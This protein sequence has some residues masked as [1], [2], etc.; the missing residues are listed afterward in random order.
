MHKEPKIYV[1]LSNENDETSAANR[2]FYD[3][4]S[5]FRY[6]KLCEDIYGHSMKIVSM[7]LM[8]I[9]QTIEEIERLK[10]YEELVHFIHKDY[11]ELSHHKIDLQNIYW[12]KLCFKLIN[13]D[14]PLSEALK[15]ETPL[16]DNF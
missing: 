5:A 11:T 16:K 12:K 9:K 6:L 7:P 8:E 10:R 3:Y 13:E 1:V 4:D 14:H 2:A 15:I